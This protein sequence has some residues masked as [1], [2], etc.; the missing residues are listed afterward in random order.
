MTVTK[1]NVETPAVHSL[2]LTSTDLSWLLKD[3]CVRHGFCLP[4]EAEQQ[5]ALNT[6]ETPEDF[7]RAVFEAEGLKFEFADRAM[8][9]LILSVVARAFANSSPRAELLG[10]PPSVFSMLPDRAKRVVKR[11][12]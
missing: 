5:L 2:M 7:T 9:R 11:R 8:R 4:P 1:C 6:P 10:S 12:R 3:L